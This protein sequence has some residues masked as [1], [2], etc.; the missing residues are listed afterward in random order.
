MTQ[1]EVEVLR[2]IALGQSNR[3]IAEGLFIS[4]NTVERH[5][6]NIFAKTRTGNRADA[7][8]YAIRNELVA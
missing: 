8:R 4:L 6:S 7:T 3:Q 1:R 2:L 5:V